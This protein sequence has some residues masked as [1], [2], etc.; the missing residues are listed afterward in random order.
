MG[1]EYNGLE[2]NLDGF[3]IVLKYHTLKNL[4]QKYNKFLNECLY[5]FLS[6][7]SLKTLSEKKLEME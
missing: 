3:K 7:D 2:V 4:T 6:L 1:L 5:I